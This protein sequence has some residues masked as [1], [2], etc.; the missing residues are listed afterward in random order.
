MIQSNDAGYAI[1][2][3]AGKVNASL[4]WS[5]GW[6]HLAGKGPAAA[7]AKVL[8]FV[9]DGRDSGARFERDSIAWSNARRTFKEIIAFDMPAPK[10]PEDA[11]AAMRP[12]P[13]F[14]VELV[15]AEPLIKSPSAFDW[16]AQ[17]RLWVVEMPDY[18][19][20]MDGKGQPGGVVKVL[21]DTDGDGRY[22]KAATFLEGLAYPTGIMPWR[23]GVLIAAAADILFAADTDGDGRADQRRVL[24]TGFKQGNEQHRFNGFEWGLDGWI[25]GANGDSGGEIRATQLSP[26]HHGLLAKPRI[27]TLNSQPTS[28]SGRDFRFRPD[29]GQFEPE[30]GQ[31][32]YGRTRDDWGN[33][34]GNFNSAWLWHYTIADSYLRRN[35]RLAVKTTKKTLAKLPRLDARL[36]RERPAD[37]LQQR[38]GCRARAAATRGESAASQGPCAGARRARY[39][40]DSRSRHDSRGV[41]RRG[42]A[43]ARP[44]V[45]RQRIPRGEAG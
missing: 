9:K 7:H 18:P 1:H 41:A 10:S 34:F 43:C 8:P 39:L 36:R 3:W 31:T 40:G 37:S 17:G 32:Q 33:W 30:S 44:G 23:N 4:G 26:R 24:F 28:I 20:G 15:A 45:A 19:L 6:P 13:G 42:C 21:T 2:L 27:S 38:E 35:P 11:L 14:A 5:R 29:S 16:D 25:Y 12:R 22:D